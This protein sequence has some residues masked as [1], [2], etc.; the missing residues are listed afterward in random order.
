M[1]PMALENRACTGSVEPPSPGTYALLCRLVDRQIRTLAAVFP[2]MAS[3][4]DLRPVEHWCVW[5]ALSELREDD[6]VR[7]RE[8]FIE[9]VCRREGL[10]IA[11]AHDL[12]AAIGQATQE[13]NPLVD[14]V[15]LAG[16]EAV[17]RGF[18]RC[19]LAA[20]LYLRQ[21]MVGR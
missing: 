10:S 13:N 18:D 6:A 7:V 9:Y 15:V 1:P 19:F 20:A 16:R 5:G 8:A 4:V 14:G 11:R 12:A 21:P 17:R 2:E 3:E